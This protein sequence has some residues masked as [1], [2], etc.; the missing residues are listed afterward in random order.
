FTVTG[1]AYVE[2]G[3]PGFTPGTGA[4]A[5]GGTVVS[6]ASPLLIPGL[7]PNTEYDFY[8]RQDCGG[9]IFSDNADGGGFHTPCI[10]ITTFP[11]TE[12]FEAASI[13]RPCWS[14]DQVT[15]TIGWT[16]GAGAG[17]GGNITAAHS[18]T[19]NARHFGNSSGSV[20]RLVSPTLDLSTMPPTGAQVR[21]W[22]ANQD[23]F[24]DQNELRVFYR[25]SPVS[26]WTL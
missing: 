9:G 17:N 22:F 10:A 23:W 8:V 21:F 20:A 16:Y 12:D 7:T 3:P 5:G 15:G 13:T 25:T 19:V 18:G 1:T 14:N 26:P 11:Y 2:Y 24:G 6:G 4:T